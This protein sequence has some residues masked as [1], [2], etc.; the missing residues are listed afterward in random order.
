MNST[1][2]LSSIAHPS[3]LIS[4]RHRRG[5]G[6]AFALSPKQQALVN[7]VASMIDSG[8]YDIEPTVCVC[9]S[10]EGFVISQIDRYGLPLSTVACAHCGTLRFDP[11][12]GPRGMAD[13][14]TQHYQD[15]YGRVP[16]PAAYFERQRAYGKRLLG[17]VQAWL[18]PAARVLEVGCG[19]G[20]ALSVFHEAGHQVSGCDYSAPLIAHGRSKGLARLAGGDLTEARDELQ[21]APQS[22]DLVFLHH[23]FEHLISPVDWLK[24]AKELLTERG[25]II[26]AVPDVAEIEHH[27]SPNGDL[28]LFLHIAHKFNFT[29]QGL[30]AAALRAGLHS[31]SVAVPRSTSAP[32]IWVA[33]GKQ[34]SFALPAAPV[35]QG[36]SSE[37]LQ[38]LRGIERR[39]VLRGGVRKIKRLLGMGSR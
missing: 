23:V 24:T 31:A 10:T 29:M 21:L 4:Y 33:F 15:M 16:E 27:E 17:A 7:K 25:M 14:Y 37:L 3:A 20:G 5:R 6:A 39:Y 30:Q 12:L 22:L 36:S 18:P 19:A 28:R 9:G 13:F 35:W 2:D 11:Y 34:D 8:A 38:R 32:E 26:V 1:T